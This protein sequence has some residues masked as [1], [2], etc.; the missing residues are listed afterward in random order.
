MPNAGDQVGL[1]LCERPR[2]RLASPDLRSRV[3]ERLVLDAGTQSLRLLE[4]ALATGALSSGDSRRTALYAS[5]KP[6]RSV[7]R[8][9]QS[10]FVRGP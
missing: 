1:G 3:V 5:G 8:L 6:P 7:A 10:G 9:A 4:G 2:R